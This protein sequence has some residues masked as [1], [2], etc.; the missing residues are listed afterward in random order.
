LSIAYSKKIPVSQ[1]QVQE[2]R[3][4]GP[5]RLK[6]VSTTKRKGFKAP[7]DCMFPLI[8]YI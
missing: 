4:M 3:V 7:L 1:S 5:V 8:L 2:P 6:N